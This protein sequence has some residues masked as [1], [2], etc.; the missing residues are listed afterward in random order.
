MKADQSEGSS[1]LAPDAI[2]RAKKR[3]AHAWAEIYEAFSGQLYGYFLHQVR[4]RETAED[5]T[6]G[7]FLEALQAIARFTGGSLEFRAWLFQIGRHNLID[8]FRKNG[9]ARVTSIDQVETAELTR[10][11]GTLD[12]EDSALVNLE[13]A[14]ILEAVESLSP[15]QREVV[16]LRLNGGLT[17][18]EIARIVGKTPGAV[19]ALQHRAFLALSRILSAPPALS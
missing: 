6:S 5:L 19:K 1:S 13:R 11:G 9:R 8:H 4:A 2:E 18:P 7:V 3:D 15:D 17:S 12:P 16:L 10:A 14:R